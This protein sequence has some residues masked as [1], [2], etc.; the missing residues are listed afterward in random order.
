M[1]FSALQDRLLPS[2]SSLSALEISL[3]MFPLRETF[4]SD[5]LIPHK[6]FER[7]IL[8]NVLADYD[9]DL[10]RVVAPFPKE[11][12]LQAIIKL[13]FKTLFHS[14]GLSWHANTVARAALQT[15]N[16][17]QI[18]LRD[19][20]RDEIRFALKFRGKGCPDEAAHLSKEQIFE[21][22]KSCFAA[23]IA[24]IPSDTR[25]LLIYACESDGIGLPSIEPMPLAESDARST[26]CSEWCEHRMAIL[27]EEVPE[28]EREE[29]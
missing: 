13:P 28:E 29:T 27:V 15:K 7:R 6:R 17:A 5:H 23:W 16:E 22:G 3:A 11:H 9:I 19:F 2:V 1:T 8:Q 14:L 12:V 18:Q 20:T 4:V 24:D 10:S 21:D 26:L 25:Q